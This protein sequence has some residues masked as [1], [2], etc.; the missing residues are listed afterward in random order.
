MTILR[1]DEETTTS[2]RLRSFSVKSVSFALVASLFLVACDFIND[3]HL[4]GT[5]LIGNFLPPGPYGLVLLLVLIWNPTCG[6]WARLRFST[7]ELVVVLAL[8]LMCAS[9]ATHDHK[10]LAASDRIVWIKGGQVDKIRQ[11]SEMDIQ[12]GSI[13]G[14]S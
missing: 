3:Q 14:H 2:Q 7:G 5:L 8:M 1:H 13:T 10:M 6:R 9:S 4:G 11:I 12:T